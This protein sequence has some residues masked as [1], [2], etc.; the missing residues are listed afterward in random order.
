MPTRRPESSRPSPGLLAGALLGLLL[1]TAGCSADGGSEAGSD[2]ASDTPSAVLTAGPGFAPATPPPPAGTF[3]PAPESWA[4]TNPPAGYRVVLLTTEKGARTRVLSEATRAWAKETG[5]D[6]TEVEAADP[7]DYLARIQEAIDAH[8]D[9][10][11]TTGDG[12]VDPLALVTASNLDQQ[13]LVLG[14]ELAEPTLNV[15]A[16]DWD[17]AGYRGEGLGR[18][19]S[20]D[21]ASFTSR[22]AGDALRAG[23][24][25]VLTGLGGTVVRVE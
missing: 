24:T 22:R 17:G 10:V 8:P 2:R 20:F 11:V 7:D 5:V 19:D 13:F 12:L 6:L 1:T 16:A 9:L 25:A 18:P 14:A 3:T 15:T 21:P 23:V 4:G